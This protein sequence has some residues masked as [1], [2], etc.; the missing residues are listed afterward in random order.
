M[1]T[2]AGAAAVAQAGHDWHARPAADALPSKAGVA[3]AGLQLDVIP[4]ECEHRFM[5]TLHAAVDA[6]V[7]WRCSWPCSP[8]WRCPSHR[9]G[10]SG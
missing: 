6:T 9:R 8:A 2:A 5:A 1:V 10:S 3:P 7:W 4:F